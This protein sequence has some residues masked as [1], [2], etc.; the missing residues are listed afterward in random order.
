MP[1]AGKGQKIEL[2]FRG[3]KFLASYMTLSTPEVWLSHTGI[4]LDPIADSPS[5]EARYIPPIGLAYQFFSHYTLG[6]SDA[7]GIG[8][9]L[10]FEGDIHAIQPAHLNRNNKMVRVPI[11]EPSPDIPG[12]VIYRSEDRPLEQYLADE[13]ERQRLYAEGVIAE[14]H[15]YGT[16]S[17]SDER[18]KLNNLHKVWHNYALDCGYIKKAYSWASSKLETGPLKGVVYCP[19]CR[20]EQEDPEQFFCRKCA[21]PFDAHKAFMSGKQVSPDRLAVYAEDSPEFKEILAEIKLRR[22]R[23]ELLGL[24]EPAE[25]KGKKK[26]D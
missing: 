2:G 5:M 22:R 19:D 9:I 16:S 3:R 1:A 15:N 4:E 26:A 12:E 10:I 14:G 21:A 24:D 20:S 18:K 13:L 23:R 11:G 8:G 7:Q 25:T 17:D 6:A